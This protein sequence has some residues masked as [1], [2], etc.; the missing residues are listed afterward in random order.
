MKD[1]C[2]TDHQLSLYHDG[3]LLE[4]ELST[5]EVHLRDCLDCRRKLSQYQTIDKIVVNLEDATKLRATP[6]SWLPLVSAAAAVFIIVGLT[7]LVRPTP[8]TT[9]TKK[10]YAFSGGGANY[11]VSLE[12]EAYLVSLEV[13]DIKTVYNE[14][15]KELP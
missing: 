11:T 14:E 15:K 3:Q 13:G 4:Q 6:R 8:T 7:W 1:S 10:Q 12:G 5:C 9:T 2:P